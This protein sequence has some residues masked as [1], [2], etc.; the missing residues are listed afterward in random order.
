MALE[1]DA[2]F[3]GYFDASFGHGVS[4]TYTPSGGSASTIKVILEDEYL[5]VDGLT[6]GVEG[7]TP[8]AYCKTKDVS[9]ASHGDSLAFSAQTD[10]DGNTIKSAKTYSVVNV[11]PDNTGITALI[12]QEQ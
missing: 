10:L 5:S 1:F 6:V 9:S 7:S 2:D 11:Q 4:A 8:V 12:L 3:D